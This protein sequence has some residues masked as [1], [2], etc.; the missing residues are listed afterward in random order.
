MKSTR[1]ARGARTRNLKKLFRGTNSAL[2][3]PE[4]RTR[5]PARAWEKQ[6]MAANSYEKFPG[7]GSRASQTKRCGT[8]SD[9]WVHRARKGRKMSWLINGHVRLING[10]STT[11]HNTVSRGATST[12]KYQLCVARVYTAHRAWRATKGER[13]GHTPNPR[14]NRA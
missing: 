7:S 11:N 6:K 12:H 8:R 9:G 5:F 2:S 3:R 10:L 14:F 13:R 1:L 4:S